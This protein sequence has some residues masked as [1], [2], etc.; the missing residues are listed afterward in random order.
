MAF[1]VKEVWC[2]II[3]SESLYRHQGCVGFGKIY[4]VIRPFPPVTHAP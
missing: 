3:N 2:M 1:I 4:C